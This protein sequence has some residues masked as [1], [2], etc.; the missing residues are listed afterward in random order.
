MARKVTHDFLRDIDV[1]SSV[2]RFHVEKDGS[3]NVKKLSD[4]QI[5][6]LVD[7]PHFN[8]PDAIKEQKV[9]KEIEEQVETKEAEKK[10]NLYT[11]KIAE[12]K[13][14]A[15]EHN[16]VLKSAKRNDIINEIKEAEK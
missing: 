2:G 15:T 1:I 12:L 9:E 14:Y 4:E 3:I 8:E 6:Q 5:N 11:M 13:D 10:V 16:I 7:I